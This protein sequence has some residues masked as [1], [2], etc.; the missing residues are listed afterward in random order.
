MKAADERP[1]VH[2]MPREFDELLDEIAQE[3][4]PERLLQ[5]AVRLQDALR[6]QRVDTTD[7][8][9]PGH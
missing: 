5:L 4:L 7:Q 2:C 8:A 3:P 9:E 6:R 1:R